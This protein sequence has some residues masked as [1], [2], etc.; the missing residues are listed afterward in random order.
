MKELENG[1]KKSIAGPWKFTPSVTEKFMDPTLR[2]DAFGKR[3]SPLVGVPHVRAHLKGTLNEKNPYGIRQDSVNYGFT[4]AITDSGL[5]YK[6]VFNKV[7]EQSVAQLVADSVE[8][9]HDYEVKELQLIEWKKTQA[10][11]APAPAVSAP[12][13]HGSKETVLKQYNL[14]RKGL[15]EA[16]EGINKATPIS[17]PYKV[18]SVPL[19]PSTPVDFQ[20]QLSMI[21]E[22]QEKYRA[23]SVF[24]NTPGAGR[25][26]R[27]MINE[28][29]VWAAEA[30][31]NYRLT[32]ARE[33][34]LDYKE[35]WTAISRGIEKKAV[36]IEAELAKPKEPPPAPKET[37]IIDTVKDAVH[38]V[39][40]RL[41]WMMGKVTVEGKTVT[42]SYRSDRLPK[43]VG[44]E[45]EYEDLFDLEI[46]KV[47]KILNSHIDYLMPQIKSVYIEPEEK[48]W[49]YISIT[50]K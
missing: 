19:V 30:G 17:G 36:E 27:V 44:D 45:Y 24:R 43:E 33:V 2:M 50:L 15:E 37:D 26:Y 40:R 16:V 41:G 23:L 13:S 7:V 12:V 11:P 48:S 28:D 1:L 38:T 47:K 20:P 18:E 49:V 39:C 9:I 3:K 22:K 31:K 46:Q 34:V 29:G 14:I 4:V 32:T 5:I 8:W 6:L 25:Y 42:G 21:F 35:R 10:P